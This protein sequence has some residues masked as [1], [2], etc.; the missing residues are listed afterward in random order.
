MERFVEGIFVVFESKNPVLAVSKIA[1]RLE[2]PLVP[3]HD[4]H[5]QHAE[6]ESMRKHDH[7]TPIPLLRRGYFFPEAFQSRDQVGGTFSGRECVA[8]NADLVA[9]IFDSG[10]VF[11]RDM[12][13]ILLDDEGFHLDAHLDTV[14]Q[15]RKYDFESLYISY[16]GRGVETHVSAAWQKLR[17]D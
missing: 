5:E 8:Q 12:P 11:R 9:L 7:I 6:F 2:R 15:L 1:K 14:R 3:A 16:A 13:P 17:Q 10:S 4:E